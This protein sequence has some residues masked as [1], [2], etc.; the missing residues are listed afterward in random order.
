MLYS[1]ENTKAIVQLLQ[2]IPAFKRVSLYYTNQVNLR[3]VDQL[4]K[5]NPFY[6]WI[7]KPRRGSALN[8]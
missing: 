1:G 8:Q 6:G 7:G 2:N 3:V 5:T 4:C